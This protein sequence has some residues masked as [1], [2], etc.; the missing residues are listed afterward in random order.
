MRTRILGALFVSI[1]FATGCNPQSQQSASSG[2][3]AVPKP[4]VAPASSAPSAAEKPPRVFVSSATTSVTT[5]APSPTASEVPKGDYRLDLPQLDHQIQ[6]PSASRTALET[7]LS[8]ITGGSAIALSDETAETLMNGLP[9]NFRDSCDAMLTNWVADVKSAKWTT[10]VLF[11]RH[12]AGGIEAVLAFQC[13]SRSKD[14][15]ES[16]YDERPATLSLTPDAA[17]LSFIPLAEEG[18]DSTGLYRVEFS[19]AFAAVG[20]RLA[21]L[22]VYY[23]NENPCCGGA[24]DESGNRLVTIDLSRGKQVL[25][26][27]ETTQ[28]GSHD[29]SVDDVDT[30][31]V[32]NTKVSYLH[33]DAG[34][35]ESI[36]SE[37]RCTENEKPLPEV[38]KQTFRWNAETHRYDEAK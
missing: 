10:R 38:K 6:L 34:N 16:Y 13:A 7:A 17:T 15:K 5:A 31:H 28:R 23:S 36:L 20:A 25:S 18:D 30:Q 11:S 33:D 32:C 37:T 27:D 26:L 21:E 35:V 2:A 22:R 4:Q 29:D 14:V 24:D 8:G 12:H 9:E 3:S 19:Q 1:S